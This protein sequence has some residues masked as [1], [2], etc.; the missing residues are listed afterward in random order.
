MTASS[1]GR[2][3]AVLVFGSRAPR[4]ERHGRIYTYIACQRAVAGL[5]FGVWS[6]VASCLIIRRL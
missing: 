5:E 6:L 2:K 3:V 1:T 4:E